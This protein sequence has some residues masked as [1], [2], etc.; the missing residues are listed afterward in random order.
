M[1]IGLAQRPDLSYNRIPYEA[2]LA[3]KSVIPDG[4][5][6]IAFQG[7]ADRFT[8]RNDPVFF[9]HIERVGIH[10]GPFEQLNATIADHKS[11]GYRRLVVTFGESGDFKS[12]SK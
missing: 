12:N 11:A 8:A 5:L 3:A 7:I 4:D 1:N 9:Y 6:V 2:A 10:L